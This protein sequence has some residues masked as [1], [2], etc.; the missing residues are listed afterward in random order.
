MTVE[1]HLVTGD[2]PYLV[3]TEI[4]KLL[5]HADPLAVDEFGAG[6][7]MALVIQALTTPSMLADRRY[8]LLKEVEAMPAEAIRQLSSSLEAID[9]SVTLVATGSKVPAK[10][11]A[12]VKKIGRVVEVARGKRKDVSDW[13]RSEAGRRNL[14]IDGEGIAALVEAVGE[15]R[16][17][18]NNAL[19]ELSLANPGGR[20]GRAT[21][22]AQFEGKADARL[23]AL[24]DAVA[25]RQVGPALELLHRLES[26]GE[27][28]QMIFWTLVKHFRMLLFAVE[29]QPAAVAQFLGLPPWR[30]EKLVRQSRSFSKEELAGAYLA[31]AEADR[32]MKTSE[33]PEVLSLER[34]IVAIGRR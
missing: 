23:F 18:L 7:D 27:S 33:E 10:L 28:S 20:I 1:V 5:A 17:A 32:K 15:E 31:L 6:S 25:S 4:S 13:V 14:K 24:I 16:L 9:P 22:L 12:A 2:D 11:S 19:E 3:E 34:A 21:V 29:S 26:Q 8:V 30:A